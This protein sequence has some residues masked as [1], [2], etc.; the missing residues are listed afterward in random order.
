MDTPQQRP[1]IYDDYDVR[2]GPDKVR[3]EADAYWAK[4]MAAAK[5]PAQIKPHKKP[6]A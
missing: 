6:P 2:P 5:R 4:V 1:E 3:P